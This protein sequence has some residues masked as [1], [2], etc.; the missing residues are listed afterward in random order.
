MADERVRIE[1]GF[2]G[3]Q[4]LRI[5]VSPGDADRV[6]RHLLSGEGGAVEL[7]DGDGRLTIVVGHVRYLKRFSRESQIGFGGR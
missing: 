1:I 2:E 3:G 7:E 4:L 5:E 6:E